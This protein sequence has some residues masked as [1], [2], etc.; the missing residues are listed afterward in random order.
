MSSADGAPP[1]FQWTHEDR[2]EVG[3]ISTVIAR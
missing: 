3:N 2:V 1:S